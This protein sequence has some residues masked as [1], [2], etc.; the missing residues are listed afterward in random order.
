MRVKRLY[1][2]CPIC[3]RM[4]CKASQAAQIEAR[5]PICKSE[6]LADVSEGYKVSVEV[7]KEGSAMAGA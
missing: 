1:V 2:T 3:G 7:L 4:M 6:L 5:C